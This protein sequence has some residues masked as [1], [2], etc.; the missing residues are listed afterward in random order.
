[1]PTI[2]PIDLNNPGAAAELIDGVKSQIGSVPNIF[3]TFAHSPAVLDAYLAF[4]GAIGNT[5]LTGAQREQIAL[6]VAGENNCDYCASAHTA[7]AAGAGVG[8][9]EATQNLA[10]A[11]SDATTNALLQFATQIVRERGKLPNAGGEIARLRE[12]G[13][14]DA[15]IVEVIAVVGINLF[16]NYFNHIV[17][18]EIDFPKVSTA[19]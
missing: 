12:A 14:S 15:Q 19:A 7:I 10:G 6:A 3:A 1:M 18:T 11:A 17:E 5:S 13:V 8:K 2:N 9:D 4:S 16:T